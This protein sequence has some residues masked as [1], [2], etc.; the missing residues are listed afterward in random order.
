MT[1]VHE[2]IGHVISPD[3]SAFDEGERVVIVPNIPARRLG[4]NSTDDHHPSK[5]RVVSDNYL[6]NSLFLGSG[7]DG[8]A[9]QYMVLPGRVGTGLSLRIVLRPPH[10]TVRAQLTHTAHLRHL[11]QNIANMIT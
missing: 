2:G 7:Y 10:R 11:S 6:S 5:N 3:N 8:I 4:S 9:Q 1:L